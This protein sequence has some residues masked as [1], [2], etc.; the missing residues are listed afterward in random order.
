MHY[1]V[2]SDEPCASMPLIHGKGL[3]K[4]YGGTGGRLQTLFGNFEEEKISYTCQKL[5]P[6]SAVT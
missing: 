3:P 1:R 4:I 2:L 5:N 6:S